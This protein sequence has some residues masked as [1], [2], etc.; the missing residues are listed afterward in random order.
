[1]IKFSIIVPFYNNKDDLVTLFITLS[2]YKN[3]S[4]VEIIIID[5]SSHEE[6]F[7]ALELSSLSFNNLILLKNTINYGVSYTRNRGVKQAQGEFIA[8][9]DADDGWVK[10][11]A[12]IQYD[13][14]ARH[15]YDFSGG[16]CTVIKKSDFPQ[17]RSESLINNC[18]PISPYLP[19]F[20]HCF[21]TPSIML[22]THIM[23]S[24]LFDESLRYGEDSDCWRRIF[25]HHQP[26]VYRSSGTCSFKHLYLSEG[27]SLSTNT[28]L[29]SK[30]QL[31]S[32]YNQMLLHENTIKQR[33]IYFLAILFSLIKASKRQ[34]ETVFK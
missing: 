5:D 31:T 2:D 26:I 20:K 1:M 10:N 9:L 30:S 22:K 28:L 19:L 15:N 27:D 11:K 18:R 3:D 24:N 23:K 16:S 6:H 32:L 13:T 8:F 17:Y 21:N 4:S 34:L 12:Y 7:K 14:M 29:M 33:S 25:L